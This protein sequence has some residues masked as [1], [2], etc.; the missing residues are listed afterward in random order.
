MEGLKHI[1]QQC[2]QRERTAQQQLYNYTYKKLC[3]AVA[4]YAKDKSERDW[5]FNLGLMR[6]FTSLDKYAL[7]TN[8]LVSVWCLKRRIFGLVY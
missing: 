8:S 3:T 5:I 7:G 4:V 1:I 2:Q 6:I